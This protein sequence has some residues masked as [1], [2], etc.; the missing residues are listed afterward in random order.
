MSES[1]ETLRHRIDGAVDLQTAVRNMKALSSSNIGQ[2]EKAMQALAAYD[3]TVELG[4]IA[5]LRQP[6]PQL[7]WQRRQ[8]KHQHQHDTGVIVLGSDQG[9]VRQFN[10]LLV[11]FV[12][13]TLKMS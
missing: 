8:Q 11:E 1:V 13:E 10:D 6:D 7:Q 9:L 4:L 5:C 2:Y 12:Q 3:Q